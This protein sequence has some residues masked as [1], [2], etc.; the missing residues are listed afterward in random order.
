MTISGVDSQGDVGLHMTFISE[1]HA[2]AEA[3]DFSVGPAPPTAIPIQMIL[4]TN[5]LIDHTISKHP[6]Q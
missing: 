6:L 1:A 3:R 2:G 4:N 5:T